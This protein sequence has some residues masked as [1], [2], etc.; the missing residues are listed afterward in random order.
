MTAAVQRADV[1]STIEAGKQLT[2][3][4]DAALVTSS[5]KLPELP[6]LA[7]SPS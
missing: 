6:A 3:V 1:P 5:M 4:A 2:E 7:E